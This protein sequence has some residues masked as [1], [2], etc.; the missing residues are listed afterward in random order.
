MTN[1]EPERWQQS[2]PRLLTGLGLNSDEIEVR[3]RTVP[4]GQRDEPFYVTLLIPR[5]ETLDDAALD[6]VQQR[7]LP[8]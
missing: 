3:E 1:V 2:E 7:A 5:S 8:L 4:R 6:A